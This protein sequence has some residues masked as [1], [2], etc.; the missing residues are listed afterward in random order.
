MPQS[1]RSMHR[2]HTCIR[3]GVRHLSLQTKF[4]NIPLQLWNGLVDHKYNP[5]FIYLFAFFQFLAF[6]LVC[7]LFQ[8]LHQGEQGSKVIR[9]HKPPQIVSLHASWVLSLGRRQ[10]PARFLDTLTKSPSLQI[11]PFGTSILL[12]AIMHA[13][14]PFE[15][16]CRSVTRPKY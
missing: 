15:S 1:V 10:A 14:D 3:N 8:I 11:N 5:L 16:L 7:M 13:L 4:G 12:G 6:N 2:V 9:K